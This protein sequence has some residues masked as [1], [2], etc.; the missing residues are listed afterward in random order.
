MSL[1]SDF[2]EPFS[3]EVQIQQLKKEL[4]TLKCCVTEK[5][6]KNLV[7]LTILLKEN[8]VP[9]EL[10]LTIKSIVKILLE[11]QSG[12]TRIVRHGGFWQIEPFGG[13]PIDYFFVVVRYPTAIVTS[14]LATYYL[15][16]EEKSKEVKEAINKALRFN[17]VLY[18]SHGETIGI[19]RYP[20][21]GEIRIKEL[22]DALLIGLVPQ[23]VAT[24]YKED[25]RL[26][27][28]LSLLVKAYK[29]CKTS[30][31]SWAMS[32]CLKIRREIPKQFRKAGF[33]YEN[34]E[35]PNLKEVWKHWM[36]PDK[37]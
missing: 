11:K 22:L 9:K 31:S 7:N 25:D 26:L 6:L 20:F 23:Y 24:Y 8:K 12:R 4:F 3:P 36:E 1:W 33:D 30:Q 19:D 18:I 10:M 21:S 27:P 15:L 28:I 5:A 2:F 13:G 34:F 37:T 16:S 32:T 35:E 17:G 14:F 29:Y